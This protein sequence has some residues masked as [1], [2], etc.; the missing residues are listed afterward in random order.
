M[1]E[2][3]IPDSI[4]ALPGD[5]EHGFAADGQHAILWHDGPALGWHHSEFRGLNEN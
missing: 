4:P 1:R 3:P 5:D 2:S